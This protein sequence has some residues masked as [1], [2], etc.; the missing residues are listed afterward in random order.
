MRI[1]GFAG[2]VAG[3]A[4]ALG[5]ASA[6][7]HRAE[8]PTSLELVSFADSNGDASSDYIIGTV[9][10]PKNQCVGG[11]TVK[12][13]RRFPAGG[14]P[15]LIDSTRTSKNGDW[16]G[17]GVEGISSVEGKVT[18]TR[19]VLGSLVCKPVSENFD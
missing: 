15:K 12:I 6:S 18:V 8:A 4:L 16:A 3:L 17:G 19:K 7:G 13:V 11:R 10:S 1:R 9:S 14:E 5:V 2:L